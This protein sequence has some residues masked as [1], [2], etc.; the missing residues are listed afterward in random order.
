MHIRLKLRVY[1]RWPGKFFIIPGFIRRRQGRGDWT[2]GIKICGFLAVYFDY[3][4]DEKY[5][6][7]SISDSIEV[8]YGNY[9]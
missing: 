8:D 6:P 9:T 3:I 5:E 1:A 4:N 7:P 2:I